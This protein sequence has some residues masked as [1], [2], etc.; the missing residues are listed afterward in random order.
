MRRSRGIS[1]RA[2]RA[3]TAGTRMHTVRRPASSTSPPGK[4]TS[5][6]PVPPPGARTGREDSVSGSRWVRRSSASKLQPYDR[7]GRQRHDWKRGIRLHAKWCGRPSR[8]RM[9]AP[10][11]ACSRRR[12]TSSSWATAAARS[13]APTMRRPAPSSGA[14]IR[15]TAVFAAP[16]TY[17]LDGVQY[18]AASVGGVAQGGGYFAPTYAR[19]LVFALGGKAALPEPL[20]YTRRLSIRRLRRLQPG[21]LRAAAPCILSIARFAMAPTACKGGAAS[22]T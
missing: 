18:V 11:A 7:R 16:I 10:P 17:M 5:R 6:W 13:S 20:P 15:K 2:C 8:S 21:L 19:M 14:S 12:A 1:H 22:R 9:G 4:P 3:A